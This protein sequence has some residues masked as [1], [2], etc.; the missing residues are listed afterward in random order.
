M[1]FPICKDLEDYK[2]NVCVSEFIKD[3]LYF[4]TFKNKTPVDVETTHF[5][6]EDDDEMNHV[7]LATIARYF[8]RVQ[9]KLS[10]ADLVSK[11]LVHFSSGSEKRRGD[12]AVLAGAYA[13]VHLNMDPEEVSERLAEH[14]TISLKE[15]LTA[16]QKAI[17]FGLVD[18]EDFNVDDFES[19][20]KISLNWVIPGKLLVFSGPLGVADDYY[21]SPRKYLR[22]FKQTGIKTMVRLWHNRYDANPFVDSGGLDH[23]DL[24]MEGTTPSDAVLECFLEIC[25]ASDGT[26]VVHCREL[27]GRSGSL[28][29]ALLL[30]HYRMTPG[31]ASAWVRF[32]TLD[33][34][35]ESQKKWLRKNEEALRED[36]DCFRLKVFGSVDKIYH[37]NRGIYS[38]SDRQNIYDQVDSREGSVE[39]ESCSSSGLHVTDIK[40]NG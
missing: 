2:D 13:I 6:T 23:Y 1:T 17:K 4:A 40:V 25:E 19:L 36:G 37:H 12:A 22:Y 28:V 27:L 5:F 11:T 34:L 9:E 10:S 15:T 26:A 33:R 7:S 3:R 35:L 32:T 21:L 16:L 20:E 39:D 29:C 8:Q 31:E 14:S 30:K 24:S 18:F 38:N